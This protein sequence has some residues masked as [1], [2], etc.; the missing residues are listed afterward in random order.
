M[1]KIV[2]AIAMMTMMVTSMSLTSCS[3]D[4]IAD[5]ID[6]SISTSLIKGTW[7]NT[8]SIETN[9]RTWKFIQLKQDE[10]KHNYFTLVEMQG[11][12]KIVNKGS[13]KT[14]GN[15]EGIVLNVKEGD[16]AGMTINCTVVRSQ[17]SILVLKVGNQ[18]YDFSETKSKRLDDFLSR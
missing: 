13:W 8:S 14:V 11:D 9:A 1:K 17:I 4:D 18:E 3:A 15:N 12:R 2:F 5:S 6:K 10:K 16:M 7:Q